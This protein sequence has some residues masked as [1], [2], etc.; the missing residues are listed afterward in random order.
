MSRDQNRIADLA[1]SE[2]SRRTIEA[3]LAAG[4]SGAGFEASEVVTNAS[5]V[6]ASILA[7]KYPSPSWD[8]AV[9]NFR[10][11]P[12]DKDHPRFAVEPLPPSDDCS[13]CGHDAG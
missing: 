9:F 11:E 6:A 7:D 8:H 13:V 4:T 2:D 1:V 12:E 3:S 5:R 10:R